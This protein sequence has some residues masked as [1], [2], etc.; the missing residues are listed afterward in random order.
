MTA[1]S[2]E[3]NGY[4]ATLSSDFV[5]SFLRGDRRESLVGIVRMSVIGR[6]KVWLHSSGVA[7]FSIFAA[8]LAG[9]GG[10]GSAPPP[11]P[12]GDFTISASPTS[13]TVENGESQTVT[14][15]V[16]AVNSFASGVS[17]IA[18]GLPTGVTANPTSFTLMPGGQQNVTLTAAATITSGTA[19][20]NFQGTS[21]SQ[22]HNSQVSLTL[23]YVPPDFSIT[24][25]PT[26]LSVATGGSQ[27]LTVNLTGSNGF[28]SSVSVI[29]TGMPAGVTAT[30]T[31][32]TIMPGNQQQVVLAAG[33]TATA[34]QSTITFTGTSGS[35]ANTSNTSL[36]V[37][38]AVTGM[39]A[40]IRTRA[41]R[42]NASLYD[43][44]DWQWDPPQFTAYDAVHRQFF[45]SNPYLNEIEV[46]SAANEIETAKIPI[47]GPWG[48][49]V[50]PFDG[51]LYVGTTGVGVFAENIEGGDI[52]VID[53]STLA[54]TQRIMASTIGPSGYGANVVLALP[55]GL[56]ALGNQTFTLGGDGGSVVVWDPAANTLDY[57]PSGSG[58]PN[59]CYPLG[60]PF[61]LSGDRARILMAVTICNTDSNCFVCSYDPVAKQA[62][63]EPSG[64]ITRAIV[65]T[66][67]GSRF[68]GIQG[69]QFTVYDA[70]TL[71]ALGQNAG[72]FIWSAGNSELTSG[73]MSLDGATLYVYDLSS[74]NVG[75][76]DTTTL[77]QIGWVPTSQPAYVNGNITGSIDETGL[78]IGSISGGVG[79]MDASLM[80]SNE[81]T[82][83]D[84]SWPMPVDGP[85]EGGTLLSD[86][87]WG[88]VSDGAALS[89]VYIGNT[90]G[91]DASFPMGAQQQSIA[92][93]TTPPSSY[94]GA[95]D[96]T[97]TL[98]DGA[99]TTCMECFSYGP[100]L[101]ELVSTA[102]TA[103]GGESGLLIGYG[104]GNTPGDAASTSVTIG[105]IP[106]SVDAIQEGA[107]ISPYPFDS[108]ELTFSIPPGIAGTAADL[109]VTTAAGSITIP[110]AFHYVAPIQNFPISDTLQQGI[111][112]AGRDLYYFAGK[113]QIEVLSQSKGTWLAPITLPGVSGST[114]LMGI[115]ESPDGTKLAVSDNG[116][117]AIYVLDPDDP[118]SATRFSLLQSA[119]GSWLA[120]WPVGLAIT[121]AG[122]VYFTNN[123]NYSEFLKLNTTTGQVTTIGDVGG[124]EACLSCRV[125]QSSDGDQIY[126]VDGGTGAF[127]VNP[128][129][130]QITLSFSFVGGIGGGPFDLAVSRDGSTLDVDGSFADSSMNFESTAVYTDWEWFYPS[131]LPTLLSGG[132]L[133][134]DGS[135]LFVPLN[136]GIDLFSRNTGRLLYRVEIPV[137]L[138]SVFDP[139]VSGNG[140]NVLAAITTNGV[141]IVDMSSL[142]VATQSTQ[143]FYTS[144]R[145][146]HCL[147]VEA[148]KSRRVS[149]Q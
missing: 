50:S 21:G 25:S 147:S 83:L 104:L 63:I 144:R 145:S 57:G 40:P 54:I 78:I 28:S 124:P 3:G 97:V 41:L 49:D 35:L 43:V 100:S 106:A 89:Q 48:L 112:D 39:H 128:S 56:F 32:F 103:D 138:A 64:A 23:S 80:Q 143:P 27:N 34:G 86:V 38:E 114:Q 95:V 46:F 12:S 14:V 117:Q 120:E 60:G 133:S 2:V 140:T 139:L 52:Y 7:G 66:P 142:P 18:S 125:V 88:T 11:P 122:M 76:F 20:V 29:A 113:T 4:R 33:T 119:S 61:S 51:N 74:G 75:A 118:P 5:L 59:V 67:D 141:S 62:T 111:Y 31:S 30:P 101:I 22:S 127:W 98:S 69:T 1:A 37:V 137:T 126:G 91:Q 15:S 77:A 81:T 42:T 108:D 99:V 68:F 8:L 70:K 65:P 10:G 13:L 115:A 19:T 102:A 149:R 107:V 146:G 36:T 17:V 55:G 44:T 85:M 79:F 116:G 135:I 47:P 131:D 123:P 130:D 136:N 45:V 9:C 24:A 71:Q 134:G 16:A 121:N 84:T 73:V 93:A 90:P 92:T 132:K 26:T 72:P 53:T 110:G 87:A 148:T 6:R 96:T 94:A 129:N 109:N 58:E 105:G 82:Y